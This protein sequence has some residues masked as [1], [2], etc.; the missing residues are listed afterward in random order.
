MMNIKDK[1][2]T[3]CMVG[4]FRAHSSQLECVAKYVA[5]KLG[6]NGASETAA[7]VIKQ[8]FGRE[9][10]SASACIHHF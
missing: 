3:Q 9:R 4:I 8:L 5:E 7:A 1:G 2:L 10:E 6:K